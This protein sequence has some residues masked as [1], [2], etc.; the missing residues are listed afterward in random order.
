MSL[1]IASLCH[2]VDHTGLTNR[3]LTLNNSFLSQLYDDMPLEKHHVQVCFLLLEV[4]TKSPLSGKPKLSDFHF[5]ATGLLSEFSEDEI[6]KICEEIEFLIL[7]TELSYF[8][9]NQMEMAD[10]LNKNEFSFSEDRHRQLFK[11]FLM[12]CCDLSEMFKRFDVAK[13]STEN[14]YREFFKQVYKVL[15]FRGKLT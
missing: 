8:F 10:L 14:L 4:K 1:F 13:K 2:D 12:I 7:S 15:H 9:R 5:Q 3:F 11:G 6:K